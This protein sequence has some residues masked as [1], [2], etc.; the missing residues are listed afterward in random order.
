MIYHIIPQGEKD[1]HTDDNECVCKPYSSFENGNLFIR[2]WS[3][4]IPEEEEKAWSGV[5]TIDITTQKN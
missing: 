1:M 3:L 2:H 5:L 4:L